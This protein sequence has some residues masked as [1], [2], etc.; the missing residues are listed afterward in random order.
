MN[1]MSDKARKSLSLGISLRR[2][3]SIHCWL[4]LVMRMTMAYFLA[5][6]SKSITLCSISLNLRIS[7]EPMDELDKPHTPLCFKC[8]DG[9]SVSSQSKNTIVFMSD[10]IAS[11][12]GL[13]SMFITSGLTGAFEMPHWVSE[14]SSAL[15][16]FDLSS[17]LTT[18]L[19]SLCEEPSK[20]ASVIGECLVIMCNRCSTSL[21]ICRRECCRTS[22]TSQ[23]PSSLSRA[24]RRMI[25]SPF[26]FLNLTPT[27]EIRIPPTLAFSSTKGRSRGAARSSVASTEEGRP[28]PVSLMVPPTSPTTTVLGPPSLTGLSTTTSL[29]VRRDSVAN[30][31]SADPSS[32]LMTSS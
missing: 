4:A 17:F 26:V 12:R 18:S 2:Q 11:G 3:N 28:L 10:P 30:R 20:L 13:A 32:S 9:I 25:G 27:I 21:S 29:Q 15:L 22:S 5:W 19:E 7:M 14:L 31:A 24:S 8:E 1:L 23:C 16:E 6:P